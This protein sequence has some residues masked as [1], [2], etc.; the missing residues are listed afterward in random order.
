MICHAWQTRMSAYVDGELSV[1][2]TL[3]L[4]AHL[5]TCPNCQCAALEERQFRILLRRQLVEPAPADLRARILN[6]VRPSLGSRIGWP[7]RGVA[8]GLGAAMLGVALWWAGPARATPVTAELVAAHV[9]YGQLEGPA[10]FPSGD[11]VQLETWFRQRARLDV[12]VPDYSPAGIRLLGGRIAA[13][14][15]RRVA[16]LVYTKGHTLLSV[17]IVPDADPRAAMSGTRVAYRGREYFS[18][19]R[20]GYRAVSWRDGSVTFG[21][22]SLLG[23]EDLFRCA[24]RLREEHLT[25][26]RLE[27]PGHMGGPVLP[28][29]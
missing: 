3:A 5:A 19:E 22:A 24:D 9:A 21:L 14:G 12:P 27:E 20:R 18:E 23:D 29:R 1:E 8:G 17:F 6:R 11:G 13:A 16:H 28:W 2:G 7:W 15:A 4:R 25:R 10:E 26:S